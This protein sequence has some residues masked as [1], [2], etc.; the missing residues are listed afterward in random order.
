MRRFGKQSALMVCVAVLVLWATGTASAAPKAVLTFEKTVEPFLVKHCVDCH[1]GTSKKTQLNLE[2]VKHDFSVG[3]TADLWVEA[4]QML[5]FD[6]MPPPKKKRPDAIAKANVIA[7][8]LQELDKSGRSDLY[9]KKLLAPEYGNWVSH[10]KLFSGEIETLPFSPSR[11]WRFSPAIFGS[12][13]FGRARSPF[14]YVTP[15][16]G[17]RDYATMSQVDQSTVQMMLIAAEQFLEEREK[18]G[19]FKRFAAGQPSLQEQ[20]LS[21]TLRREFLRVIGRDPSPAEGAKYLA[22]LKKNIAAGSGIDGLKTTIKAMFLSPEAIYRMEFGLGDADEHGRRH[23]S[24]EELA[25]AL[26]YALTDQ[27]PDR[28]KVIQLAYEKGEL[29]TSEDAARVVRQMLEEELSAG[30]SRGRQLPRIMRFFEEF[31]GFDRAGEVFKDNE[32]KRREKIPQWNT[33]FLIRD[34]KLLIGHILKRDRDVIAQLLTTNRYFIA[35][36]G[37]NQYAKEAYDARIAEITAPGYVAAQVAMAKEQIDRRQERTV[38]EKYSPE[39]IERR[40]DDARKNA[41]KTVLKFKTALDEGINPFPNGA[42]GMGGDL[43]YIAPYNLPTNNRIEQQRWNWPIEQPLQMPKEQRAGLLTHPAWLAA[44]SLNDGNDPIHRGIW[45]RERLLAGVIQD[46][47]PDVDANVPTDPHRTLRERLD[48]IRAERCWNC[49]RKINPLGETFEMFDD[50]G[51][52]RTHHYFNEDGEL[53]T[54]RDKEFDKLLAADKLKTREVDASGAITGSGDAEVDGDVR[55]AV[56][57]LH[58]LGRSERARH[59]FI[60]HLFRYFMGRNEMLSDSKT[61][62]EAEQAY[63]ENGGSFKALVVSL[64][65][66]DSFLYRR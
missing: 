25:H 14:T 30:K 29:K 53:V 59:S 23:L 31:F 54:R 40:L 49:H 52:Y 50:W 15:E 9:H 61:L 12:K 18:K 51:R 36:P 38:A 16:T 42:R 11:L 62:I 66:S 60:R 21:D 13:G 65:S 63:L 33:S 39:E 47:P 45:V 1:D 46:V 48:V 41:E 10:E 57:M 20:E 58:R 34:A 5:Q 8:V 44:W 26:A 64:L 28:T 4:M 2:S 19:E 22:F 37:D 55:N 56:D 43:L 6:E 35:H 32:R 24:P 17:I 7:W 27:A 3:K